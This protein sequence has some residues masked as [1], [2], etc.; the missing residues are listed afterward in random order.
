MHSLGFIGHV[1]REIGEQH[2]H[3]KANIL[4]WIVESVGELSEVNFAVMVGI[5][6]H[7]YVFNL[8]PD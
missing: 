3:R 5:H 6:A 4:G 8:L 7:H 1:F 2:S